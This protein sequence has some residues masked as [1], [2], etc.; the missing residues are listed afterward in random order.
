MATLNPEKRQMQYWFPCCF[1]QYVFIASLLWSCFTLFRLYKSQMYSQ[2]SQD[3]HKINRQK[4]L[5]PFYDLENIWIFSKGRTLQCRN[6]KYWIL[7][8]D[9]FSSQ[10]TIWGNNSFLFLNCNFKRVKMCTQCT[11]I[12]NTTIYKMQDW[13][14]CLPRTWLSCK[15]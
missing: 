10:M 13:G 7:Y 9:I 15:V 1:R 2:F 14:P 4:K 11:P 8:T 12:K 6:N 3:H 5:I